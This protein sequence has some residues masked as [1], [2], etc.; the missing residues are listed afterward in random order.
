MGRNEAATVALAVWVLDE[1]EA[2]IA[3]GQRLDCDL[4]TRAISVARYNYE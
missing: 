1:T 4:P 3:K 2:A